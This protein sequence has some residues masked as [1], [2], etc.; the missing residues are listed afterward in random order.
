MVHQAIDVKE[1]RDFLTAPC[2]S[3]AQ[4]K[5]FLRVKTTIKIILKTPHE[6][7]RLFPCTTSWLLLKSE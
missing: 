2:V 3:Q 1:F 5:P 6:A 7:Q 4:Y